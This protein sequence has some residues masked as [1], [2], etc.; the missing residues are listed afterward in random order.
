ME[1]SRRAGGKEKSLF[2]LSDT[3]VAVV[4]GS[5]LITLLSTGAVVKQKLEN[6]V[7]IE[8]L[9]NKYAIKSREK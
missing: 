6:T 9:Q 4:C 1:K 5:V 3:E 7:L 8:H 2:D